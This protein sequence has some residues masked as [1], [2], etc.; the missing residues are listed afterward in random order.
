MRA[1]EE[2]VGRYTLRSKEDNVDENES[3]DSTAQQSLFLAADDARLV[4]DFAVGP[5]GVGPVMG[6]G[7]GDFFPSAA[8]ADLDSNR[9]GAGDTGDQ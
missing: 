8:D 5:A 4:V 9:T 3:I 1:E 7:S 6:V 2:A